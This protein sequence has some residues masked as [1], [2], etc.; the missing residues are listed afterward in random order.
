[1]QVTWQ[2]TALADGDKLEAIGIGTDV[3]TI[4]HASQQLFPQGWFPCASGKAYNKVRRPCRCA[5]GIPTAGATCQEGAK[6]LHLPAR[7]LQV[8]DPTWPPMRN[9]DYSTVGVSWVVALLVALLVS[10][11]VA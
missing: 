7:C 9:A 1:M 3:A 2:G 4:E 11:A 10:S 5:A 6:H 8:R